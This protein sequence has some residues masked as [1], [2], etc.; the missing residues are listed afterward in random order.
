MDSLFIKSWAATTSY[1]NLT[2]WETA[3]SFK[4][5]LLFLTD[6]WKTWATK[7][8]SEKYKSARGKSQEHSFQWHYQQEGH[9]FCRTCSTKMVFTASAKSR[10]FWLSVI[11]CMSSSSHVIIL[12]QLAVD[13]FCYLSSWSLLGYPPTRVWPQVLPFQ[14]FVLFHFLNPHGQRSSP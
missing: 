11:L 12:Q 4:A 9:G 5:N 13:L 6:D 14:F 10:A 1:T 3:N 8:V 7:A 2:R